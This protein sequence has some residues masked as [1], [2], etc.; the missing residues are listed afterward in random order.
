MD[1][2]SINKDCDSLEK[3]MTYYTI[4]SIVLNLEL[5]PREIELLS[6]TNK[7]GNISSITAKNAYINIF[8]SSLATVN[9]MISKLRKRG[10]LVKDNKK[11]VVNSKMSPDLDS[12][13]VLQISLNGREA[14]KENSSD[15]SD[16]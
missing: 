3:G 2:Q 7:R 11:I 15:T 9:N 4:I 10:L 1:V 12:K 5:T 8:G 14:G 16:R 13:I 6:F